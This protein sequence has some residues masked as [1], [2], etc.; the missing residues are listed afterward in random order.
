MDR[1]VNT[2]SFKNV[3]KSKTVFQS[4]PLGQC[5]GM[6]LFSYAFITPVAWLTQAFPTLPS[7]LMLIVSFWIMLRSVCAASGR[8]VSVFVT[9]FCMLTAS[10]MSSNVPNNLP[11]WL[12]SGPMSFGALFW[13]FCFL[14]LI[15][16]CDLIWKKERKWHDFIDGLR[17]V[18][19]RVPAKYFG[20]GLLA[21]FVV[22]MIL[23]PST[24]AILQQLQGVSPQAKA[25]EEITLAESIRLRTAE[26][27]IAF[28]FFFFGSSVGSF[29][30]V[31]VY[32]SP[33]GISL[34]RKGSACPQCGSKILGRDNIPLMGWICLQG[35]CRSCEAPIPIR[36]PL[37]EAATGT[38][39]LLF[40]F[41]ELL[42]G[43]A[44]LPIRSPNTYTGVVWIIFYTKWDLVGIYLYHCLLL[45][46]LLTQSL[47][48]FDGNRVPWRSYL[49]ASALAVTPLLIWPTLNLVP[50]NMQQGTS[51][52]LALVNVALGGATGLVLGAIIVRLLYFRCESTNAPAKA[53]FTMALALV[54][55]ILGWQA[56][57]SVLALSLL[58]RAIQLW[59]LTTYRWEFLTR[60]PLNGCVFLA[61]VF[62]LLVW[63]LMETHVA[64]YWPVTHASIQAG[65]V[66][67]LTTLALTIVVSKM[68]RGQDGTN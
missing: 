67:L 10:W 25:V 37:V 50:W 56:T 23:V 43:G 42:S 32:R 15:D 44:N 26:A 29:L 41:A 22:Y 9:L 46:T 62:Q 2:A 16:V 18:V 40:Y 19:T 68:H 30:N 59:V 20:W 12:L 11:T 66:W 24:E 5:A 36:Y 13:V 7:F 47:I 60:W 35:K 31:V 14:L 33:M 3:P 6:L 63:R 58:L 28:W 64:D 34:I 17:H 53:E 21:L 8:K 57:L 52:Q 4:G 1:Q 49:T 55:V 54:G 39:F 65:I 51:F 61:S 48:R 45:V 38:L 27:F